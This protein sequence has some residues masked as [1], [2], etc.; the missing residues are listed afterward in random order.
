MNLEAQL[1][2]LGLSASQLRAAF[3]AAACGSGGGYEHSESLFKQTPRQVGSPCPHSA[4]PQNDSAQNKTA[5]KRVVRTLWIGLSG[6]LDSCVLALLLRA[7]HDAEASE[8]AERHQGHA[9]CQLSNFK[10]AA[11][12]VNH[13]IQAQSKDWADWCKNWCAE[14][15]IPLTVVPVTLD[16]VL[17]SKSGLEAA[18]RQARYNAFC[19][20]VRPKDVIALAHHADDQAETILLR[21]LR[22]AGIEGLAGMS[23]IVK[24]AELRL[25]RPLLPVS[26]DAIAQLA[27]SL[28]ISWIEDPSNADAR[29]D[30]NFLR[31]QVMPS[32]KSRWPGV[33]KTV[34]RTGCQAQLVSAEVVTFADRLIDQAVSNQQGIPALP[35][36]PLTGFS[37]HA[38]MTLLRR[39]LMRLGCVE[40]SARNIQIVLETV[41]RA[42]ED[43]QPQFVA[44]GWQIRRFRERLFAAPVASDSKEFPKP[45]HWFPDKNPR[46]SWG[47]GWLVCTWPG[48]VLGI[49]KRLAEPDAPQG[50]ISVM[51]RDDVAAQHL[52]RHLKQRFQKQAVPPWRRGEW[53]ILFLGAPDGVEKQLLS[54]PGLWHNQSLLEACAGLSLPQKDLFEWHPGS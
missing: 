1:A 10:F 9:D 2:A 16:P 46:L 8:D 6:G 20:H 29:F 51:A 39:W 49:L 42:R 25:W 17:Q 47:S 15:R 44:K 37:D 3:S 45:K 41:V 4:A 36:N 14:R 23:P 38:C 26:R 11:L 24:R 7:L 27:R 21:W 12:H 22:G 43:A 18:A 13:Q 40:Y 32:I 31:H 50:L 30:R 33:L 52:P 53:P 34:A 5:Q 54:V 48:G 28:G 19:A 35:L